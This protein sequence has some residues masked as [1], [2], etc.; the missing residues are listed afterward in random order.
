MDA[1]RMGIA[2][3]MA[4]EIEEKGYSKFSNF[5]DE[6]TRD[7]LVSYMKKF[8]EENYTEENLMNRVCYKREESQN[9]QG[10]AYMVSLYKSEL[11]SI[12]L[13]DNNLKE[14]FIFYHEV[15]GQLTKRPMYSY[16]RAMLNCQQ[17]FDESLPVFDHYDG[18]FFDFEHGYDKKHEEKVLMIKRGLLPRY[19]MVLVLYNENEGKGTYVRFHHSD[20]RIELKNEA[21][22]IIIFDNI[23]MR[24]GVPEMKHPRM[25]IGFR[26]FDH[27]PYYFKK[28]KPEN[29]EDGET[30][31][32]LP[33]EINPGWI[34]PISERESFDIQKEFKKEWEE[35]AS[36]VLKTDAAF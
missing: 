9:R 25:M 5:I 3:K 10:D 13:E 19:V 18:E 23:A 8:N 34:K 7:Q 21:C 12:I 22:D 30:W 11:P 16:T 20:E 24:H 14:L 32:E 2:V 1:Y 35:K 31:L 15:M 4:E 26:N 17:Y 27:Y 29:T 28:S 36:E 33:D 6:A